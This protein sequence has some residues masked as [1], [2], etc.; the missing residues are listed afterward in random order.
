M[1]YKEQWKDIPGYIGYYQVSTS[2]KVRS[3]DRVCTN[4]L[5]YKRKIKGKK[6]TGYID[7]DGY[8]KVILYPKSNNWKNRKKHF[9]HQLVLLSFI[10]IRPNGLITRHIDGNN[11]N[12]NL[13]NL[14]YGTPMENSLDRKKHKTYIAKKGIENPCSALDKKDIFLIKKMRGKNTQSEIAKLIG[15]SRTT[16]YRVLSGKRYG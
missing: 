3:L 16:I 1:A 12:N 10:G 9:I 4:S 8:K 7:R 14:N 6:I 13:K 2:G 5:G 11:K 15:V